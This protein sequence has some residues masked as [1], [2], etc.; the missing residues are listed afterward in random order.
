MFT[1]PK[2][3]KSANYI[4]LI[5]L[6]TLIFGIQLYFLQKLGVNDGDYKGHLDFTRKMIQNNSIIS[7]D[8]P[9]FIS[10]HP[11][12]HMLTITFSK[13]IG[14]SLKVAGYYLVPLLSYIILGLVIYRVLV[15][16]KIKVDNN[17][18]SI[19]D[20][21][22]ITL[23]LMLVGPV[24]F[25]SYPNLYLGYIGINVYHSPTQILVK[26]L[27]LITFL[28]LIKGLNRR[29]NSKSFKLC[30]ALVAASSLMAKPSYLICL[31]PALFLFTMLKL[32]KNEL[33]NLNLIIF[34]LAVNGLVLACQY[35]LTLGINDPDHVNKVIFAPFLVMRYYANNSLLLR[36]I[37]SILFPITV[38]LALFSSAKKDTTLNLAWLTFGVSLFYTYFLAFTYGGSSW[39]HGDFTWGSQI[40]LFILF[41][42][43]TIFLIREKTVRINGELLSIK[44]DPRL[45]L[46]ILTFSLHLLSGLLYYFKVL[47]GGWFG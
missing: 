3:D 39:V 15:K 14:V 32:Y 26:P 7:K 44:K 11:L 40:S 24:S 35:W 1:H 4:G 10:A 28:L 16:E 25:F 5:V 6:I 46:C 13:I 19:L 43:S 9:S 23:C 21:L 31:I 22:I 41:V 33:I 17:G 27:S 42:V 34:F 20:A 38:Y 29:T 45:S 47:C 12:Y 30:L 2:N 18:F 36:L 37:A 8:I